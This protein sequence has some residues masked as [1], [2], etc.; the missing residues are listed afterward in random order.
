MIVIQLP[1]MDIIDQ[2]E[3]RSLTGHEEQPTGPQHTVLETSEIPARRITLDDPIS[4]EH[5]KQ[6]LYHAGVCN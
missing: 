4:D 2:E 6:N 5:R 1:D 3:Y